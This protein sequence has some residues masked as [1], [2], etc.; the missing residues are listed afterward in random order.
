MWPASRAVILKAEP[1]TWMTYTLGSAPDAKPKVVEWDI[2]A[3]AKKK[4]K[5]VVIPSGYN[6]SLLTEDKPEHLD[7][8]LQMAWNTL[9]A[10]NKRLRKADTVV[11][12]KVS[13]RPR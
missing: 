1:L 8:Q 12:P 7:G 5:V 3:P 9:H 6:E 13:K 4:P 11:K 2:V 10:I